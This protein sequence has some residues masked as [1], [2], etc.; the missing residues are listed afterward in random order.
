MRPIILTYLCFV[1][2]AA[3][4]QDAD[5]ARPFSF[6]QTPTSIA[7][8]NDQKVVWRFDYGPTAG[9]PHF[10]PI[11]LAD[12][13][14]LTWHTPKDHPWHYGLWLS[15]K[16]INAVNFW[17]E[18]R[19]TQQAEGQTTWSNVRVKTTPEGAAQIKLNLAY[20][21]RGQPPLL[22]EART[23]A[24]TPPNADG[25]YAIDWTSTFTAVVDKVTLNRTPLPGEPD[26]KFHGGYAG[27]TFRVREGVQ[28]VQHRTTSGPATLDKGRCRKRDTAAEYS[29]VIENHT[30]GIC[31]LDHPDNLNSPTP[32]YLVQVGA[33]HYLTPAVICFA[34]HEMTKGDSFTLR[35]R[36]IIH[37]GRWSGD[38]L[39][40][41]YK[42]FAAE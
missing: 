36:I 2:N 29:G 19:K 41:Q 28:Q 38:E 30:F 14:V 23:I 12:G 17:E 13:T 21:K 5:L 7:L 24:I 39:D 31:M 4:A 15:W 16:Y 9:K 20:Q 26:G 10:H 22:R 6:E 11:A 18:D 32:W 3:F 40:T 25:V 27:L 8:L 34:P 35:Y 37:P 1:A 33:M 42:H